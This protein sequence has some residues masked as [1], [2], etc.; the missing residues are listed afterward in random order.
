MDKTALVGFDVEK[1]SRILQILED[2]GL[3]VKVALWAFLAEYDE[4]RLVLSSRKFDALDLRE[5]YDRLHQA[6]GASGLSLQE[7]PTV[8]ILRM[9]DPFIKAL[10][11]IFAMAKSVDG[12]RLGGQTFGDRFV[13]DA[14]AYRIS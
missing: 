13:E 2:A 4:W 7:T 12:M 11:K 10:R 3:Q 6:L 1:G 9:N 5:A 8:V 14:Y